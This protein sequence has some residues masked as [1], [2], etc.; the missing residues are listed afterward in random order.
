MEGKGAFLGLV[1][2]G[3]AAC[4][5]IRAEKPATSLEPIEIRQYE[6]QN[7][8][9][10]EDFPENS[11]AGPQTISLNSY[12]LKITGMVEHPMALNYAQVLA[13]HHYRKVVTLHCV[14]EWDATI[15]W[16][17][18]LINDLLEKAKTKPE[19][20]MVIFHAA[21]GY[22]SSLP[23]EFVRANKLLLAHKLNGLTLTAERGFPF[24]VV[25]ESKWGYKWVRWV[26]EIELS[27]DEHYRGYWESRGFNNNGDQTGPIFEP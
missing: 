9:L 14:E 4:S 21:D 8:S 7:S 16:E 17:G 13:E 1:V 18:I 5:G 26:T 23:L 11:I 24:E 3:L 22:T 19:A 25:A 27:A 20:V 10:V 2:L 6:G 15:L 12:Q